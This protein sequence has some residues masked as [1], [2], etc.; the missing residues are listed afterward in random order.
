MK[1]FNSRVKSSVSALW[2]LKFFF[3]RTLK[4]LIQRKGGEAYMEIV[5]VP[6]G[7]SSAGS[8]ENGNCGCGG[9]GW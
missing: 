2:S 8:Q 6:S 9:G 1:N 4:I 3:R 5:S 7:N